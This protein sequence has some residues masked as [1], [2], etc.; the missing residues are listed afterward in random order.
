MIPWQKYDPDNRPE[1]ATY[2]VLQD[3]KIP[4]VATYFARAWRIDTGQ[5]IGGVT[6]YAPINLPREDET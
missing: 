3:S 1:N 4:R 5:R 2:F 6:H